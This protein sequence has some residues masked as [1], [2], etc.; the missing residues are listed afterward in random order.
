MQGSSGSGSSS[1]VKWRHSV[2]AHDLHEAREDGFSI[3]STT[4]GHPADKLVQLS[5]LLD[6]TQTGGTLYIIG[7]HITAL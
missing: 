7:A 5:R 3:H 1:S 4:A 2:S 6:M